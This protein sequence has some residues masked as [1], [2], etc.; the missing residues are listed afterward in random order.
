MLGEQIAELNGKMMGQRVLDALEPTSPD[1][2]AK[3][4]V[5]GTQVVLQ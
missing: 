5:K 3:G 1:A 2:P 4:S